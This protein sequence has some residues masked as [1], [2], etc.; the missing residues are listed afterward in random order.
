MGSDPPSSNIEIKIHPRRQDNVVHPAVPSPMGIPAASAPP[1]QQQHLFSEFRPF[2]RWFPWMVPTFVVA[3]IAMFLITMFINNCPKNSV[4]CVADFLG[5]FSF[6]PLKENPLLGP[7]SSTLEKMGALEVSKVVHRHQVW[8]LIS[9][10]WLHAG[11]FHV[12]ANMLSLVFIGIR[13]EQEFGF[14]RIGLLYVVSGFGGSMLSSLFIQSSI[15]VGASGALFGLLGGML[16]EL[17]TNWTIYANKF[18]ALLTLILIIIVN[19]AV[20]ILPHVDNFA[21]IGGFVSGFLLGFV[22]L[23]RPQFGWVSQRN[24]SPGHIAPSVKP[25]HKMYQYVLWV[26][27]LILLTVGFTVG[28]VMLL[29]GVSGND[30]CSWCH[31]LSCVPTSKWSCKSQQVYCESTTIGNQLNLTCLSNGR[32]NIYLLPDDNTSQV[33]QLCSQLCN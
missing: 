32:S 26:M 1:R 12:L 8:R 7:S 14:V 18:A 2:K 25:K 6:Q 19:L 24:A 9:C 21:H 22:F 15:S 30:Q 20:G 11:V 4:S 3:N 17:I 27:S 16:S 28:M 31:Y 33:Q 23:I 29:R 5:R 10:I 13:L